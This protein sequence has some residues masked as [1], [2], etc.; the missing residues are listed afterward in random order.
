MTGLAVNTTFY[1]ILKE[2]R[3]VR[4]EPSVKL[5]FR[6]YKK[7]INVIRYFVIVFYVVVIPFIDTP[8][9]CL[10]S[11][12]DND[13]ERKQT[14]WDFIIDC[15]KIDGI[16]YSQVA[17]V[18]PSYISLMDIVCITFFAY[19]RYYRWKFAERRDIDRLQDILMT[20][21]F[22]LIMTDLIIAIIFVHR[23]FFAGIFRPFIVGCFMRSVR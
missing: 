3:F 13:A 2:R 12:H 20:I 21:G 14:R 10:N 22:A 18:G 15:S 5:H 1:R 9:W 16:P 17:C 7:Y 23:P 19:S 6:I 4:D 8:N 11:Y